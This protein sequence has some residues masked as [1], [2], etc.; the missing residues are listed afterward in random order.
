MPIQNFAIVL[1]E[2]IWALRRSGIAVSTV[3]A[4]DAAR[5]VVLVGMEKSAFACALEVTLVQKAKDLVIFR[6]VFAQFFGKEA[7]PRTMAERLSRRGLTPEEA[8]VLSR[9]LAE[10][11]PDALPSLAQ[12]AARDRHLAHALALMPK[13]PLQVGFHAQRTLRKMG[14]HTLSGRL[15]MLRDAL[16]SALGAERGEL[17]LNL[18]VEEQ[19]R[20]EAYVRAAMVAHAQPAAG[21]RTLENVPLA[22]L[23]PQELSRARAALRRFSE[24][25]VAGFRQRERKTKT[26]R[27][28]M[29]RTMRRALR[30]HGVP[31]RLY[32]RGPKRAKPQLI[33]L[34]DLS[35][36]VRN[37]SSFLL[38]LACAA[39]T[40]WSKTRTFLFVSE[41]GESTALFREHGFAE[42]FRRALSGEIIPTTHIS[43]YGR[44]FGDFMERYGADLT[45]DTTV[46]ILGD[47]RTNYGPRGEEALR[48]LQSRAGRVY[49]FATERESTWGTGDSAMHNY[50]RIVTK[51][52][53]ASSLEDFEIAARAIGR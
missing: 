31:M 33:L 1:D 52:F 35:D 50:A 16:F 6:D 40:L 12:D 37:A 46:L 30:T 43:S 2:F 39:Q 49:W 25:L 34:C 21:P 8:E 18:L 23:S 20:L 26:R 29:A 36:S 19:R 22:E 11:S 27:L 14:Q 53:A 10:V 15:A 45:R 44:V 47:G 3:Q 28:H 48:K 41:I 38:E 32:Y 51:V 17:V 9:L 24:R 13:A 4:I 7:A 42:A 5:A